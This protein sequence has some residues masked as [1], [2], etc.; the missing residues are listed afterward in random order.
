MI[1]FSGRKIYIVIVNLTYN[2]CVFSVPKS[3]T[4]N[5]WGKLHQ[6]RNYCKTFLVCMQHDKSISALQCS[7]SEC[8]FIYRILTFNFPFIFYMVP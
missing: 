1:A 8:H 5:M 3:Q 6:L 2:S 4:I 7:E